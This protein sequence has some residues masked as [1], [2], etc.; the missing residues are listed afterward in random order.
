MLVRCA[1]HLPAHVL[2]EAAA[3]QALVEDVDGVAFDVDRLARRVLHLAEAGK[4]EDA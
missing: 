4:R 2:V 1:Y 3:E